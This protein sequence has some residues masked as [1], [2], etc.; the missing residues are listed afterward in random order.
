MRRA[1]KASIKALLTEVVAEN[2]P[3]VKMK[4]EK[5]LTQAEPK[6]AIQFVRLAAD[7]LDGRPTETVKLDTPAPVLIVLGRGKRYDP[8]AAASAGEA[9]EAVFDEA[10]PLPPTDL[11]ARPMTKVD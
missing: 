8:L 3:Q 10:R 2:R 7:S 5:G 6:H 1:S 11:P 9:E 4:L